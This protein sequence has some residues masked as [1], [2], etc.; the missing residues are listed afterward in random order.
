MIIFLM[1]KA[2][3]NK[4]KTIVISLR[5]DLFRK[6]LC[7]AVAYPEIGARLRPKELSDHAGCIR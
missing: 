4:K 7:S 1:G 6:N 2:V 3:L 5:V